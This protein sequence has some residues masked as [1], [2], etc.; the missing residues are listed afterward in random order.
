MLFS[1]LIA[2]MVAR[3]SASP[4]LLQQ[5]AIPEVPLRYCYASG[6]DLVPAVNAFAEWLATQPST[7]I[8]KVMGRHSFQR[9]VNGTCIELQMTNWNCDFD[10]TVSGPSLRSTALGISQQ[11]QTRESEGKTGNPF[12][13]GY[14]TD[15]ETGHSYQN[16]AWAILQQCQTRFPQSACGRFSCSYPNGTQIV[17]N[18]KDNCPPGTVA[19]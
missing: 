16:S 2:S 6:S 17:L 19:R 14:Y 8:P 13:W 11:C 15:A 10:I 9:E 12:G 7:D 5:T 1:L 3:T 18:P 4:V